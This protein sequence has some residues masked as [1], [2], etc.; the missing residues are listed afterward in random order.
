MLFAIF[1]EPVDAWA[2]GGKATVG[3]IAYNLARAKVYASN[4]TGYLVVFTTTDWQ[5]G[6]KR[7]VFVRTTFDRNKDVLTACALRAEVRGRLR[8]QHRGIG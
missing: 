8:E 1:T 6:K 2:D 5:W 7:P 4:S 3:K